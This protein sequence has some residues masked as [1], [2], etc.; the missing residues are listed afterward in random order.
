MEPFFRLLFFAS[1]YNIGLS[2]TLSEQ[3]R[4]IN[5]ISH[6]KLLC[7]AGER[8]QEPGLSEKYNELL[9]SLVRIPG[10]DKHRKFFHISN[11]VRRIILDES[12]QVVHIHNNWQLAIVS[13]IRLITSHHFFIVYSLHGYRH[14]RKT[15]SLLARPI[16]GAALHLF[17]DLVFAGSTPLKRAIPFISS[18]CHLLIQGVEENLFHFEPHEPALVHHKMI[19][20][21]QFRKGKNHQILI[22]AL[23]NYVQIT[24]N[25]KITCYLPGEG[26]LKQ[27]MI[28][29]VNV[30]NLGDIVK[31]P[32]QL[33]RKEILELY[34]ICD[35]AVIPSNNETFGYCIA[36]PFVAGLCTISR[37]TGIAKDI[38]VDR[39]TGILFNDEH[40]LC[41]VFLELFPNP[42]KISQIGQNGYYLRETFRWDRINKDYQE[43]IMDLI[44]TS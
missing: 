33:P 22:R 20:A 19:F 38:I 29:L 26:P 35:L 16:I 28:E 27:T 14:N 30:N 18:K 34:K 42:G 21:A 6:F 8:E 44:Q 39:E 12:I 40:D 25:R 5:K 7:V 37:P 31:F 13:Y 2:N 23:I 9:I 4:S 11:L 36:E 10:L 15:R 41:K 24:G 43:Y 32:G 3:A 17:A 1:D